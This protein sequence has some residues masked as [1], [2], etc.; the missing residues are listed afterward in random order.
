MIRSNTSS[1]RHSHVYTRDVR[2]TIYI[3]ISATD[4]TTTSCPMPHYHHVD[5][6]R[7]TLS[8]FRPSICALAL[9]TSFFLWVSRK[10]TYTRMCKHASMRERKSVSDFMRTQ[11]QHHHCYGCPCAHGWEAGG[12]CA[13]VHNSSSPA[14]G[15]DLAAALRVEYS[16]M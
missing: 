14:S 1:L 6:A 12:G 4:E 11:Q 7:E 13:H 9:M 15:S 2:D 5:V 8:V 10:N 3:Y 16:W